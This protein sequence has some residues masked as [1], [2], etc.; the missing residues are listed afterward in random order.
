MDIK[1]DVFKQA[2]VICVGSW[3][4]VLNNDTQIDAA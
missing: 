2:A 4:Q 3:N 1:A